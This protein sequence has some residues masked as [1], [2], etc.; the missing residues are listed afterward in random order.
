MKR[1]KI[2]E[3]K[4]I[5]NYL[6]KIGIYSSNQ[7]LKHD[8]IYWWEKKY[9]DIQKSNLDQN[10]KKEKLI[11][12]N[13]IRESLE[14]Y[15][16]NELSRLLEAKESIEENKYNSS[17]EYLRDNSDNII[18]ESKNLYNSKS[19]SK[20]GNSAD[21]FI[22]QE[23]LS[24]SEK[25]YLIQGFRFFNLGNEFF[26][27][28]LF[29]SNYTSYYNNS[30]EFVPLFTD[31]Y[32]NK[33][34]LKVGIS[35]NEKFDDLRKFGLEYAL[36]EFK[37]A[38]DLKGTI[39]N[40]RN[41]LIHENIEKLEKL[42]KFDNFVFANK[43]FN[44]FG[45]VDIEEIKSKFRVNNYKTQNNHYSERIKKIKKIYNYRGTEYTK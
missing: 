11:E 25:Q 12:I 26:K 10:L 3:D 35:L 27:K 18:D 42:L 45:D 38:L 41:Y 20:S 21:R 22:K 44:L 24:E 28:G 6:K 43:H 15:Q 9:S 37:Y 40:D 13:E 30:I 31:T 39:N 23:L 4:E 16:P 36:A 34:V 32:N 14:K 33:A 29:T 8:L 2:M 7:I 19:Y 5:K 1:K 17:D